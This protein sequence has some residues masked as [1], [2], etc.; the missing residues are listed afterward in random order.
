M[1]AHRSRASQRPRST[2]QD[3]SR[4]RSTAG[5]SAASCS[6]KSASSARA[7]VIAA[8][9]ARCPPAHTRSRCNLSSFTFSFALGVASATSVRVGHAVGAG[10]LELA[11]KRGLLGIKLG[12]VVMAC[13]AA[14]FLLVPRVLATRV[15]DRLCCRRGDGAAPTDRGAVSAL[16]RHAGD[17]RRRA[18]RP[19]RHARDARRATSLGHYLDRPAAHHRPRV[20]P[21]TWARPAC[22]SGLSAG[23]TATAPFLVLRFCRD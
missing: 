16:R 2:T 13:F 1:R 3:I 10:D 12:L 22:G 8:H 4:S 21:C 17:R 18:A 9:S 5:R 7:T 11:R 6:W 19:R 23:L 20:R 14:T 15:H